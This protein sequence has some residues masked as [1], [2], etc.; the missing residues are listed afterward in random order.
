MQARGIMGL[1]FLF[2]SYKSAIIAQRAELIIGL[3]HST[4]VQHASMDPASGYLL[5][6]ASNSVLWDIKSGRILKTLEDKPNASI[7][8]SIFSRTGKFVLRSDGDSI[9]TLYEYPAWEKRWAIEVSGQAD[10]VD[11]SPNDSFFVV[12][13]AESSDAWCYNTFSGD[14]VRVIRQNNKVIAPGT[15]HSIKYVNGVYQVYTK[16]RSSYFFQ[17]DSIAITPLPQGKSTFLKGLAFS[18]AG[19]WLV[20]IQNK[21]CRLYKIEGQRSEWLVPGKYRYA[22]FSPD[23]NQLVL[24]SAT[25]N[26]FSVWRIGTKTLNT[27]L[28]Y[29]G[30]NSSND[31]DKYINPAS[32]V[33]NPPQF[34][35][36]GKYIFAISRNRYFVWNAN[37]GVLVQA[38]P[39]TSKNLVDQPQLFFDK[40]DHYF[41]HFSPA[42]DKEITIRELPAAT[43]LNRLISHTKRFSLPEI[44]PNKKQFALGVDSVFEVVDMASGNPLLRYFDSTGIVTHVQSFNKVDLFTYITSSTLRIFSSQ[45]RQLISSFVVPTKSTIKSYAFNNVN[46]RV[47]VLCENGWVYL[48][49]ISALRV[50]DSFFVSISLPKGD[51]IPILFK[52]YSPMFLGFL[53]G[54]KL[55]VSKGKNQVIIYSL[56]RKQF[57]DSLELRGLPVEGIQSNDEPPLQLEVSPDGRFMALHHYSGVT[58][59]WQFRNGRPSPLYRIRAENFGFFPNSNSYFYTQRRMVRIC[60][61]ITGKVSDSIP[62]YYAHVLP[63]SVDGR[64]GLLAIYDVEKTQIYDPAARKIIRDYR[65]PLREDND[66]RLGLNSQYIISTGYSSLAIRDGKTGTLVYE[67]IPVD[68]SEYLITDSLGRYD[69]SDKA[70][71]M[72]YAACGKEII[73]LAQIKELAWEPGLAAKLMKVNLEKITAR[74]ITTIDICDKSPIVRY[75]SMGVDSGFLFFVTARRGGIGRANIYINGRQ[76]RSDSL[77]F[78]DGSAGSYLLKVPRS[79]IAPF[80]VSGMQNELTLKATT[81]DGVLTSPSETVKVKKEKSDIVPKFYG[82]SVGVSKYTQPHLKLSFAANDAI[83]FERTMSAAASNFLQ[84]GNVS[85]QIFNTADSVHWPVKESIVAAFDSISRAASADDIVVIFLSGHGIMNNNNK[86]FYFLLADAPGF[87]IEGVENL[88]AISTDELN[89]WIL[90]MKAGKVV[91][92]LDA[93]NSGQI[94]DGIVTSKNMP[95]NQERALDRLK[96]ATGIY[97]LAAAAAGRPSFEMSQF[98]QGLLTYSL[99]YGIKYGSALSNGTELDISKWF[100]FAANQVAEFAKDMQDRQDPKILEN[101]SFPIGKIDSAIQNKIILSKSKPIFGPAFFLNE[102]NMADDAGMSESFNNWLMEKSYG[103]KESSLLYM[104]SYKGNNVYHVVGLYT[105]VK[106]NFRVRLAIKKGNQTIRQLKWEKSYNQLQELISD[107]ANAVLNTAKSSIE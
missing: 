37:T 84:P 99:L 34:S 5:T 4:Q 104:D 49:N 106:G 53:P 105:N 3:G 76:I 88:V 93:C 50:V 30:P 39:E 64:S 2:L 25:D 51:V 89:T 63:D 13:M 62:Y 103:G 55:A 26:S 35:E 19:K 31:P 57:I 92:I 86:Q 101:V 27:F 46:Q 102:T 78:V 15:F 20:D 67:Y 65:F 28:E 21:D 81:F 38:S 24:Q 87:L 71:Q 80:L 107:M 68:Q 7:S 6:T 12:T 69:G 95:A 59:I 90:K 48:L 83:D 85:S 14:M 75:D 40:E 22:N 29:T 43:I 52:D 11:F 73:E 42:Q 79:S 32:I 98:G 100:Q 16:L 45:T 77:G 54:G 74:D 82:I 96:S 60:N 47:A 23:E 36:G 1:I 33:Q 44:S 91:L 72:I 17:D 9:L 94:L 10:K 97:I 8:W 58:G 66:M 61:T 18:P 41:A 56:T 70:R